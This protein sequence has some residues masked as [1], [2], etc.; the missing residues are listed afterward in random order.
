MK[1]LIVIIVYLTTIF[2]FVDEILGKNEKI[3]DLNCEINQLQFQ[4]ARYE[5]TL[6][7]LK[8]DDSLTYNKFYDVLK[9]TE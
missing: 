7:L 1:R 3:E 5:N 6:E 8:S 2:L 4:N 9:N